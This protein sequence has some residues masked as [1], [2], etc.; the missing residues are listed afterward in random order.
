MCNQNT[1]SVGILA[2]EINLLM[3]LMHLRWGIQTTCFK[4]CFI[5]FSVTVWVG[6]TG[7]VLEPYPAVFRQEVKHILS[8]SPVHHSSTERHTTTSV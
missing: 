6:G 5:L 3:L 1:R 8:R 2:S 4:T 7:G